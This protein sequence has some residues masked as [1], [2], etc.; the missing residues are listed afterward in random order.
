MF[1]DFRPIWAEINL[2]NFDHN[3][4]SIKNLI[5]KNT[6][7]ISVIKADGYGHGAIELAQICL[8]NHV[9][10]MAV[11]ILD[12]A[13]ELRAAGIKNPILILGYTPYN[14]AEVIVNSGLS[15]TCY[16]YELAKSLSEA[17][18]K[19]GK[20]AKAHIT[21]DT[22]MGRLGFLPHEESADIIKEISCLPNL[23]IEGLYTHFATADE[24]DKEYANNQYERYN[25]FLRMLEAR[26]IEVSMKHAG[27]SAALMDLPHTNLDAVRPGIIQYGLYP[28]DQVFKERLKL[29]PVMSIKANIVHVKEVDAGTPI[30]Y[31][32]KFITER[33]SKIA[34]LPLGYADGFTRLLFGKAHV[35][36][37]GKYAPIVGRICMDQCMVDVTDIKEVN[38]GDEVIIMGSDGNLEI[39]ADDIAAALG[40]INYEIVCMVSRRVP[41]VYIRK[42]EIVKVKNYLVR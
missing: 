19:L 20:I 27:N 32:R 39:S 37:N 31:G 35:I 3:I 11:A 26:G 6:E 21:V 5:G 29:K 12:E 18:V 9:E 8:E 14:M 2:D 7:L 30:S 40:T 34:T 36:V 4:K 10:W 28:S 16:S 38:V 33:K 23:K 41:R 25:E 22:G 1:K 17:A 24:K 13:L 42:G 15:Q